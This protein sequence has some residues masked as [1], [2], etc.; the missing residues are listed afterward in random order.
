MRRRIRSRRS[1]PWFGV[2]LAVHLVAAVLLVYF[3][4]LRQ[5]IRE[6]LAPTKPENT[7]SS[8]TLNKVSET[9]EESAET[10]TRRNILEQSRVEREMDQLLDEVSSKYQQFQ[11]YQQRRAAEEAIKE[12][13]TARKAL[14]E[15][16]EALEIEKPSQE[17]DRHLARAQHAQDRA[18][19][20][21]QVVPFD[22]TDSQQAQAEAAREHLQATESRN[23]ASTHHAQADRMAPEPEQMKQQ[24]QDLQKQ[25]SEEEAKEKPSKGKLNRLQKN[26]NKKSQAIEARKEIVAKAQEARQAAIR[27]ERRALEAQKEAIKALEK[28][29]KQNQQQANAAIAANGQQGQDNSQ[30][31]TAL[32]PGPDKKEAEENASQADIPDLYQ[33]G[34]EKEDALARKLKEIR[35]MDLAMVRDMELEQARKNIDLVRPERPELNAELIRKETPNEERFEAK[36]EEIRKAK[37]ETGSMVKV[38]YQM[39]ETAKQSAEN[40]KFGQD[41]LEMAEEMQQQEEFALL[42]RDLAMEDIS[43]DYADMSQVMQ[44]MQ[45]TAASPQASIDFKDLTTEEKLE[46]IKKLMLQSQGQIPGSVPQLVESMVRVPGRKITADSGRGA[47]YVYIDRWWTIGPWPNPGRRNI[48]R[49]YPPDTLVDLDAR[50]KL[51]DG[52]ELKWS[53]VETTRP[54]MTPADPVEYGIWYAYT[55]V[56]FEEA[57][58]MLLAT[59]SDDRGILYINEIPV[60]ISATQ[61]KGWDI[62]EAWRKVH[63][64]KGINRILFRVENGHIAVGFSLTLMVPEVK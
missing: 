21:L 42:I 38:A 58:D 56:Y 36:K 6:T 23:D 20:K 32:K 40:L 12:M 31:E 28:E 45:E 14:A 63:F 44:M 22:V 7:M 29:I 34:K 24:V 51:S 8:E 48:D 46:E 47:R 37:R 35:A 54:R 1:F 43:G 5:V 64:S 50:Y 57:M 27:T 9:I 15:S 30:G 52:R 61:Q 41:E 3:T 19:E 17:V 60:W 4:P 49:Q 39:L 59:G 13:E 53:Y 26:L 11:A 55:E 62:D 10:Q 2:S 25:I 33:M 16:L 18:L